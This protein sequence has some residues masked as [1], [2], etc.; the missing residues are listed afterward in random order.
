MEN[1]KD[2]LKQ[3]IDSRLQE[4]TRAQVLCP[5]RFYVAVGAVKKLDPDQM[6]DHPGPVSGNAPS[7]PEKDFK[8]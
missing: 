6:N 5:E 8:W 2:S 3:F 7:C 1:I 4:A